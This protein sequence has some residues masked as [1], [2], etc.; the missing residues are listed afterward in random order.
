MFL[1]K[2][3]KLLL[4]LLTVDNVFKEVWNTYKTFWQLRP[5][6]RFLQRVPSC[7]PLHCLLLDRPVKQRPC[8]RDGRPALQGTLPVGKGGFPT[9]PRPT[10]PAKMIRAAGK[11]QGKIKV[12]FSNL[13]KEKTNYGTIL[14]HWIMP[15]PACKQDKQETQSYC[16]VWHSFMNM[17]TGL[18]TLF[19]K[20]CQLMK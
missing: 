19:C 18:R 9:P 6:Q 8:T 17:G 16:W 5:L 20:I 15:N 3:L 7:F 4:L 11:W 13:C 12:T 1:L 10:R 2:I 14:Q